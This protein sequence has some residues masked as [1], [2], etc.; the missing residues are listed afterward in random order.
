MAYDLF[1]RKQIPS[2]FSREGAVPGAL[3]GG[4]G[5]LAAIALILIPRTKR[6]AEAAKYR[7]EYAYDYYGDTPKYELSRTRE[8]PSIPMTELLKSKE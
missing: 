6:R 4:V 1:F 3:A 2:S 7:R 5:I 8:M